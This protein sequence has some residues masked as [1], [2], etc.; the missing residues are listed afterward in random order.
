MFTGNEEQAVAQTII[1][2][3]AFW[4]DIDLEKFKT[5][6]RIPS[7]YDDQQQIDSLKLAAAEVNMELMRYEFGQQAQGINRLTDTQGPNDWR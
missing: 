4:P 5:Q 2:N 1:K 6:R 3:A 7:E